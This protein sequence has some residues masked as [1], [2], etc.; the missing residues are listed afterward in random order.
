MTLHSFAYISPVSFHLQVIFYPSIL[1]KKAFVL[2]V[3]RERICFLFPSLFLVKAME[4][5]GCIVRQ[6]EQAQGHQVT[7]CPSGHDVSFSV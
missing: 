3:E 4:W 6:V 1:R 2:K 5:V 7:F